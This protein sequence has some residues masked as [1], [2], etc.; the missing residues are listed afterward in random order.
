MTE[1]AL[2]RWRRILLWL[3]LVFWPLFMW[4][5]VGQMFTG[6]ELWIGLLVFGL[7]P[8]IGIVIAFYGSRRNR[9]FLFL[10]VA[11][12][13]QLA[14]GAI[15]RLMGAPSAFWVIPWLSVAVW[16]LCMLVVLGARSL[17]PS[18][19]AK[20]SKKAECP[21]LALEDLEKPILLFRKSF[22]G[23][24]SEIS[25]LRRAM[26]SGIKS[27]QHQTQRQ[28]KRAS[29]L[30]GQV[31]QLQEELREY[32]ALS[33]LAESQRR[34]IA[35]QFRRGQSFDRLLSFVLGLIAALVVEFVKQYVASGSLLPF[36]AG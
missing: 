28:Q 21:A 23:F 3:C 36:L 4:L 26:E 16:D 13:L 24:E 22:A 25:S 27:Y 11:V 35:N 2:G 14:S 7:P 1:K 30:V 10:F 18:Y 17:R 33:K 34:A 20:R 31:T 19:W 29:E 15:P 6:E 9:L 12:L 32:Q 5:E 8:A